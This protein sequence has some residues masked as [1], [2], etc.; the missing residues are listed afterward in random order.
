MISSVIS[1]IRFSEVAPFWWKISQ[2]YPML[3]IL[4]ANDRLVH[5]CESCD[6]ICSQWD[7]VS[8]ILFICRSPHL[9]FT[10]LECMQ[11][12]R[13]FFLC[14]LALYSF[15]I[16]HCANSAVFSALT[17]CL[18]KPESSEAESDSISC[19]WAAFLSFAS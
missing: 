9:Q 16:K 13:G 3:T 4:W 5:F 2:P 15:I 7:R 18:S 6:G 10:Y 14:R 19:S 11:L 12:V 17:M 1:L 8:L